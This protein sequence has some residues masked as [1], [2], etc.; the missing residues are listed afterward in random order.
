MIGGFGFETFSAYSQTLN[1]RE[2]LIA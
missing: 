2:S 1:V